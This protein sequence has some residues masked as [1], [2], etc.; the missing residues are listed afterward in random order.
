LACANN[1][2][3]AG[4][5]IRTKATAPDASGRADVDLIVAAFLSVARPTGECYDHSAAAVPPQRGATS[6]RQP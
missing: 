6:W 4:G 3:E 1:V 5:H 2:A